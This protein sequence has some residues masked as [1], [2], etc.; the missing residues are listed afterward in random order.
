MKL[1]HDSNMNERFPDQPTDAAI[2]AFIAAN[3]RCATW[4]RGLVI[5]LM[6]SQESD[7][8][9]PVATLRQENDRARQ[10]RLETRD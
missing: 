7:R 9:S 2:D 10:V 5:E 1:H 8:L 6:M 4:R 3:P